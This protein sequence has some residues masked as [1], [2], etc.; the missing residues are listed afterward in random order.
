[1]KHCIDRLFPQIVQSKKLCQ[2]KVG[3]SEGGALWSIGQNNKI[4]LIS[5]PSTSP[6]GLLEIKVKVIVQ[7]K[8]NYFP[9]SP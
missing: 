4:T 3:G 5:K 7:K 8:G 1:M 2:Y 6:F 9:L